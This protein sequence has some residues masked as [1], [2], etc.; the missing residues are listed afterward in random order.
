VPSV[1]RVGIFKPRA[2]ALLRRAYPVMNDTT[3]CSYQGETLMRCAKLLLWPGLFII[4]D[5]C[6]I[7]GVSNFEA[8]EARGLT[9]FR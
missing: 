9:A 7:H 4:E 1:D 2:I 8:L 5:V 6:D 3:E